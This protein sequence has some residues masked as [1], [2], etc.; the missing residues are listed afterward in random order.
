MEAV[1]ISE[2][3]YWVGV[4]DWDIRNFHGYLTDR[5]STYN[6]YLIIDEHITLIDT[7]KRGFSGELLERIA[8]V[9]EPEKIDYIVSNHVEMDHSGCLAEMIEITGATLYTSPRGK[10]GLKSHYQTE[11]WEIE[12]VKTGDVLDL[13]KKQLEFVLTPMVHWPDNMMTYLQDEGI[14]FSNDSFGQ[15]YATSERFD[16]EVN[17]PV[18]MEEAQTYYANIVMPY[19]SQVQNEFNTVSD[20]KLELNVIAPSHGI[21]WSDN[22]PEILEKY[23][24]WATGKTEGEALIVYDTMWKSTEKMAYALQDVFNSQGITTY[25]KNL[26]VNHPSEIVPFVLDCE[27][28]CVGSPTL[29]NNMMP[30]VASF[31]TYL[32]GLTPGNRKTAA[33][34]SYG[35]SGQSIGLVADELEASKFDV[36]AQIKYNFVPDKE[37]LEQI[38]EDFKVK[39]ND[40]TK[41]VN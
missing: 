11:G 39:L 25:M 8:S 26:K 1:K 19:S 13:G 38:K 28:I 21:I 31:L 36:F 9:I 24:K 15:H 5:G 7:V 37:D 18:A 3:I 14:L 16:G 35:W 2:D 23:K 34:G 10:K 30:T 4:I 29:N 22:I 27:Y 40:I 20:L 17:T 33:F 6:A 41:E 12:D 32:K